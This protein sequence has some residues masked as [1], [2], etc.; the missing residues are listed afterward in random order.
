MIQNTQSTQI[1][2]KEGG[3]NIVNQESNVPSRLSPQE[4][5]GKSCTWADD[6]WFHSAG[7]NEQKS[8]QESKEGG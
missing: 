2:Q 3:C 6:V 8:T 7:T 1:L 5:C 4:I